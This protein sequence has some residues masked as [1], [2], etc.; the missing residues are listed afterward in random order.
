[1][2]GVGISRRNAVILFTAHEVGERVHSTTSYDT[3]SSID[4]N[5]SMYSLHTF[6][7]SYSHDC[8]INVMPRAESSCLVALCTAWCCQVMFVGAKAYLAE[9]RAYQ[10]PQ[11]R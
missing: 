7:I 9:N 6:R 11:L 2:S 8:T 3:E 5:K 10:P 1:M 4:T